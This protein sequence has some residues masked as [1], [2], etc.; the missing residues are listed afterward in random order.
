MKPQ[1]KLA[2]NGGS[3]VRMNSMPFRKAF[4]VDEE[5]ALLNAVKY[6]KER[7]EDPP[8]QG[9]FEKVFC[10]EFSKF[11]GGG[12]SKAVSSGTAACFVAI[13]SLDLPKGS[14]I[15]ISPV[16]DS[17]PL[18]AIIMLGFKP[19]LADSAPNSYN[20]GVNQFLDRITQNTSALFAVH[21]G[22]EP[23]DI[24]NIT[25]EAHK[26]GIKVIEDCSQAPGAIHR[27]NKVGSYGDV[28]A[29]STMYRKTLTAGAS[30][31]IVYTKDK[32]TYNNILAHS[33]RGKQPW[34][35]DINQSDPS[36]GL[37]PA[38]NFNT[39]ELSCSIG[40]A[41]LNRLQDTIDKRVE[42]LQ[43]FINRLDNESKF[44]KAYNFDKNFS[45]FYLPIF[46]N[47]IN[48]SCSKIEFAKA[49]SAEG[50]PNN[51]HYGCVIS[52]WLYS[53]TY[54]KDQ[55]IAKNAEFVR[56]N[57]FNLFINERYGDNEIDDI[58]NA[59]I[60]IESVYSINN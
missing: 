38:L 22:G 40:I 4:G 13:A 2:I 60:K 14:E 5:K 12:Y 11:I 18:N 25:K 29:F 8:Y 1:N 26:R 45:P 43:C 59:I 49:L 7:L 30:G 3:P 48:L 52:S 42:F 21:T 20:I 31:G 54:M 10:E 41:S 15:I 47:T 50:I 32:F 28:A 44:C 17:G 37:F 56:D 23:L 19:V 9:H 24:S 39:D 57:S 53:K 51:N 55:F 27:E 35:T 34:R 16:T 6:Y 58:V 46:V 33:D 36:L